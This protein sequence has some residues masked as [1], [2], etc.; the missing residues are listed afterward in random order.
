MQGQ[1]LD[2]S[3]GHLFFLGGGGGII[4]NVQVILSFDYTFDYSQNYFDTC[5]HSQNYFLLT[6]AHSPKH[7]NIYYCP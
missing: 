6:C 1:C 2:L 7:F 3:S 4:K 5:D